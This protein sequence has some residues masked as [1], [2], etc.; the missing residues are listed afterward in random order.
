MKSLFLITSAIMSGD[1]NPEERLIQTLH[2]IDS[3]N[4]RFDNVEIWLIDS[5]T[6]S[7][8]PYY[9]PLIDK[10]VK[11]LDLSGDERIHQIKKEVKEF[12]LPV[13]QNFREFYELGCVKNLTE[14]YVINQCFLK[15][16]PSKYDRIYKISGRY[17]LTDKFK[18]DENNT[19]GKMVLKPKM[20]S[21]LGKKYISSDYYRYCITWNFCTSIFEE[22]KESFQLIE[23]Y[24]KDQAD[25]DLL[26]DIEHGL[27]LFIPERLIH[28]INRTGVVG[29]VNGGVSIHYD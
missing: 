9:L 8:D 3:I 27:D 19:P 20:K 15:I 13:T 5:S 23:T 4:C 25:S 24:L 1:G 16:D 29:R 26:G 28:E 6:Q 12:N 21:K 14:S 17:F 18:I 22:I 11:I 2:T 10:S 7:L